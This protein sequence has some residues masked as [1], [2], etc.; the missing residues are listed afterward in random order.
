[1]AGATQSALLAQLPAQLLPLHL[2][3]AQLALGG[4]THSP[5]PSQL[6][7]PVWTFVAGSQLSSPQG[8]PSGASWQAPRPSHDPF[9]PH[10]PGG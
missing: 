8:W 9:V 5:W 1:V 4:G 10:E 3:G 6:N 2:K 7:W